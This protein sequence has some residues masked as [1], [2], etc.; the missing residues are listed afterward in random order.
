MDPS[1]TAHLAQSEVGNIRPPR[2]LVCYPEDVETA[3]PGAKKEF[4]SRSWFFTLNNPVAADFAH[5]TQWFD[6]FCS[7]YVFQLEAGESGTPH[8]QG[9]TYFHNAVSFNTMR[10]VHGRAAWFKTISWVRAVQ[11]CTKSDGCI[12]GP[13]SKGVAIREPLRVIDQLRPWQAA[14]L[15][16]LTATPDDRKVRWLYDHQGGTGKTRF[17][18]YCSVKVPGTV[19]VSGK[20]GDIAHILAKYY[21]TRDIKLVIF[22]FTRSVEQFVS[23]SMIE[24]V[25]DGLV[26]SG[27]YDSTVLTF[28]PPHV[29]V[30][31][32]FAPD[33]SK[34]SADRWDILSLDRPADAVQ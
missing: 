25:K 1:A 28:N 26:V 13:W 31:A 5:L 2:A 8:Y 20:G 30:L 9:V 11:Y 32:N 29:L 21:E 18:V 22:T 27:K 17:A 6:A 4:R 15:V 3:E 14:E 33:K 16:H 23:Y 7:K 12:D 19:I 34:L 10:Q 24:S